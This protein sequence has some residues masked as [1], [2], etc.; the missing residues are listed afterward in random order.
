MSNGF[1][2]GKKVL[3]TGASGFL[4]GWVCKALI[5]EGATVFGITTQENPLTWKYHG[6]SEKVQ[7]VTM[8]ITSPA[9][10]EKFFRENKPDFCFHFAGK[11]NPAQVEADPVETIKVNVGGT[12]ALALTCSHTKVPMLFSS[13]INIFG[14]RDQIDDAT[15]A[16]PNAF[17]GKTKLLAEDIL[18]ILAEKR[19]LD[20]IIVRIANLFGPINPN[21]KG[22]YINNN[23]INLLQKKPLE[24]KPNYFR[25]FVYVEDAVQ[26]IFSLAPF[27][28][29]HSGGSFI[30]SFGT[31][32]SGEEIVD[33]MQ[34]KM[35]GKRVVFTP[36]QGIRVK[37]QKIRELTGWSPSHSLEDGLDK[38]IEWYKQNGSFR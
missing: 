29:S 13:T 20:V 18:R 9:E 24:K 26:G 10:V 14:P 2:N 3:V 25:D 5:R 15:P 30:L 16:S 38:T 34:S 6:I 23:L 35:Q 32:Y 37:G 17:Y 33:G 12:I 36:V 22:Q 1:W 4:G 19:I 27:T 31:S 7:K 21:E 8:D 28:A 11:S